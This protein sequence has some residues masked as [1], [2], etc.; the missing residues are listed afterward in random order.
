MTTDPPL[1]LPVPDAER[2]ALIALAGVAEP[3]AP[4]LA[5]GVQQRGAAATLADLRAGTLPGASAR[6]IAGYLNRLTDADPH[7]DLERAQR[8]GARFVAPG[9]DEWPTALDDLDEQRPLGLWV[10]GP[11]RLRPVLERSVAIVGARSSTAYGATVAS[12][13]AAELAARGWTVVSGGAF[14]IDAAAHRGALAVGGLTVAV[15]ACGVDRCYPVAHDAL[16]RR[17]GEQGLLVSELSPGAGVTRGRFL[18]RNRLLAAATRGTVVVEAAVRSGALN[19]A[20]RARELGRQVMVV[21]GPVT[22]AM[23]AGCHEEIRTRGGSLVTDAADILD[24]VGELGTDASGERREPPQVLDTLT[25]DELAVFD[26][27]PVRALRDVDQL[28]TACAFSVPEVLSCLGRLAVLG[29]VE[30]SEGAWRRTRTAVA[31]SV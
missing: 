9:D 15:L 29:L 25:R 20:T 4:F 22:S 13:L 26:A 18:V 3:P 19:T 27:L 30:G 7:R 17:I 24:L 21:P 31:A 28:G 10:R 12:E 5:L 2:L 14:G 16:L 11:G 23:S 1:V 8:V 6:A